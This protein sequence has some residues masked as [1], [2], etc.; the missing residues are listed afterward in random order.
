MEAFK[1]KTIPPSN[2]N[3]LLEQLY[4]LRRRVIA[5]IESGSGTG[6]TFWIWDNPSL[7]GPLHR[8]RYTEV[9]QEF[10]P[11]SEG[12]I[13]QDIVFQQKNLIYL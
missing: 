11:G 5:G 3:P 13:F 4:M 9:T 10:P 8:I 12:H 6:L 1:S 7:T 2:E